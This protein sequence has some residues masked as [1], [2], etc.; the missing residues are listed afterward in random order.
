MAVIFIVMSFPV[1]AEENEEKPRLRDKAA[2]VGKKAVGATVDCLTNPAACYEKGKKKAG[3][4]KDKTIE[5]KDGVVKAGKEVKKSYDASKYFWGAVKTPSRWILCTSWKDQF[6]FLSLFLVCI[7]W[8]RRKKKVVGKNGSAVGSA[9]G[10][11]ILSFL[12]ARGLILLR[13][14]LE[15]VWMAEPANPEAVAEAGTPVVTAYAESVIPYVITWLPLVIPVILLINLKW[16]IGVT[17]AIKHEGF[18]GLKSHLNGEIDEVLTGWVACAS[19]T[20]DCKNPLGYKLCQRCRT[21]SPNANLSDLP[22]S[23]PKDGG[24]GGPPSIADDPA[25]NL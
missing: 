24:T 14:L 7:Y 5:I 21:L 25:W 16:I 22:K 9:L 15:N 6:A 23:K 13:E 8:F 3:E 12:S 2:E 20:C 17:S 11:F 1:Y 18:K 10:I 19:P 4:I